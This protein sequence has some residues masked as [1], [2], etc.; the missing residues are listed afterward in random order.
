MPVNLMPMP[1]PR[2]PYGPGQLP[3]VNA[4]KLITALTPIL[5]SPI[6]TMNSTTLLAPEPV[7]VPDLLHHYDFMW[8]GAM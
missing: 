6:H 3:N 2:A 5:A 8:I 7:T 4:I 1:N